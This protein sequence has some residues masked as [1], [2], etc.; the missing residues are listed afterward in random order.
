MDNAAFGNPGDECARILH[1]LIMDM[2]EASTYRRLDSNV[3]FALRDVNG[4]RVG[5]AV[6]ED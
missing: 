5:K 4:N 2:Q 6:V 3:R 1:R